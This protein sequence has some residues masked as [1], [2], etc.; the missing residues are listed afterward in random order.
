MLAAGT[1]LKLFDFCGYFFFF[2][3]TGFCQKLN[4]VCLSFFDIFCKI[5][6]KL[7]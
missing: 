7:Y 6:C 5:Q 3:L 2:T 4:G 1:G